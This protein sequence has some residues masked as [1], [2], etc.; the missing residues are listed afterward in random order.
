MPPK[1]G[2]TPAARAG[3]RPGGATACPFALTLTRLAVDA[4]IALALAAVL[5]VYGF[6]APACPTP[7]LHT[8][9][10]SGSGDATACV[11]AL[12]PTD[13]RS[14]ADAYFEAAAGFDGARGEGHLG[15]LHL[16]AAFDTDPTHPHVLTNLVNNYVSAN[17]TELAFGALAR[18]LRK[19]PHH[20]D[21]RALHAQLVE[22]F[23]DAWQLYQAGRRYV[24]VPVPRIHLSLM[25]ATAVG[26]WD[27]SDTFPDIEG[28]NKA[29]YDAT[30]EAFETFRA[31]VFREADRKQQP[32]PAHTALNHMFFKWQMRELQETGDYWH[33]FRKLP[34]FLPLKSMFYEAAVQL[35]MSHGYEEAE[36]RKKAGHN[37]IFWVSVHVTGSV[38]EPHMTEDS[39]IGG[40]YYVTVP[41]GSGKLG[42]F[43][44]RGRS[45]ML[46]PLPQSKGHA[47]PPFHRTVTIEPR[48]G[49]LV[50][51]PGWL[52]HTV[53]PSAIPPDSPYRVS[54]SV[55][56]KGEWQD[57]AAGSL[58]FDDVPA[59]RG[60]RE[61]L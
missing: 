45:P 28:L 24:K 34:Y 1:H 10:G 49:L 12:S 3:E 36:A 8:T 43:D 47:V 26:R 23:P 6:G 18:V 48:P 51:F 13:A 27:L 41:P 54:I 5:H 17:Y 33:G 55:N 7:P 37:S 31:H 14:L 35:L 50:L 22:L 56:L 21:A 2:G 11:H 38:H 59:R 9:P 58:L 57:T 15:W 32:R 25:F 60:V 19:H 39:L 29:F 40:V 30:V 53:L 52:V 20:A 44:P 42:L 4:C 46:P 16:L 61:D